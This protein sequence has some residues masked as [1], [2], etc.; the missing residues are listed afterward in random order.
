MNDAEKAYKQIEPYRTHSIV[1]FM[2]DN[3][4]L[5]IGVVLSWKSLDSGT[6]YVYKI[7]TLVEL[8]IWFRFFGFRID[9]YVYQDCI[10]GVE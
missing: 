2:D 3:M 8:P 6:N 1:R 5:Q 7:R 10:W 4:N 9:S